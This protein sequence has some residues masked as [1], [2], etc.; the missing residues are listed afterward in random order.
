VSQYFRLVGGQ[1][2]ATFQPHELHL[3]ADLPGVLAGLGDP[4]ADPGARRLNPPAYLGDPEAESEWRRFAGGELDAAR[5]ADR[6]GFAATVA[7]LGRSDEVPAVMTL[8]E[9]AAF[10]RVANEVRLVLGARW[11]IDG[12]DDYDDL[13]PEAA[14]VLSFLGWLVSELAGELGRALDRP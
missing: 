2:E 14:A 11:G 7:A 5:R 12:P 8:D 1:I 6:A 9:A 10:M 4:D 3:L 13:R